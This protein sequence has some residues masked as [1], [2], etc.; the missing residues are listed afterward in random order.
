MGPTRT[1]QGR[2]R[3][4]RCESRPTSVAIALMVGPPTDK[5]GSRN[6]TCDRRI[7]PKSA[8]GNARDCAEATKGGRTEAIRVAF[9]RR[10]LVDWER[11]EAIATQYPR[12]RILQLSP[13]SKTI[14]E[15][16]SSRDLAVLERIYANSVLVGDDGP[17]GWRIK[18]RLEF[19]MNT[20]AKRFPP[21]P[22][23]EE[24]GYRPDEYSRWI[25]GNWKPIE[26]L[27]SELRIIPVSEGDWERAQPPY[28][29][30]PLPRADIPA[31]IIL[32]RTLTHFIRE[33]DF[34]TDEFKDKKG[35]IIQ[36]AAIALPLYE[37]RMIGQFDFSQKSWVS[38]KGRSAVW[39]EI[40]FDFKTIEPQFLM[41][42]SILSRSLLDRYLEAVEA[43][44]GAEARDSEQERLS[45]KAEFARWFLP[46]HFRNVFMDVTSATNTRGMIAA[47]IGAARAETRRRCFARPE[48]TRVRHCDLTPS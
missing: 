41:A 36:G 23:W 46:Q 13:R 9:M 7:D 3:A 44:D 33:T 10:Q 27:W 39:Q 14:L 1:S 28:N 2:G 8:C 18:F 26:E 48:V 12:D 40:P 37:G 45:D 6:D 24:R 22:W 43:R 25:K 15:I 32:S 16:Q 20:D 42:K 38:G 30:L 5:A 34:A 19:M 31:G 17:D 21:R 4:L 35:N 47:T 29:R 11:S